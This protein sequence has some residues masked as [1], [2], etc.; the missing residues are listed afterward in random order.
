[1]RFRKFWAIATAAVDNRADIPTVSVFGGSDE[2]EAAAAADAQRRA[3]Q[4][5]RE[6]ESGKL[7][8]EGDYAYL[9]ADRPIR[10]EVVRR[11]ATD[12][13]LE[14]VLSR[15]C[16][17]AV[18]LNTPDVLFGDVDRQI[19]WVPDNPI[20]WLPLGWLFKK[21]VE[22]PTLDELLGA[23]RAVVDQE[24]SLCFVVYE[25]AAGFRYV[26]TSR[27]HRHN[28]PLVERIFAATGC[29]VLYRKLCEVQQCFRAR[30]SPKPWRVGA[31]RPPYRFPHLTEDRQLAFREWVDTYDTMSVGA[32]TCRE[33]ARVGGDFVDHRVQPILDLHDHYA[34]GPGETLA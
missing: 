6:L 33:V 15:S 9:D 34:C 2:S 27:T 10:E 18:I 23:L 29:D 17:G 12:D 14:V 3:K 22:S 24:P 8:P 1:M 20:P 26:E 5:A 16:Y 13:G 25:T 7:R 30:I 4:L 28:D 32:F 11:F 19:V 21:R 31:D